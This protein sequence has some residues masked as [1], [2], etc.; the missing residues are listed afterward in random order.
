MIAAALLFGL[1]ASVVKALQVLF[2]PEA[3]AGRVDDGVEELAV[4]KGE[5]S[6]ADVL[7][8]SH[9]GPPGERVLRG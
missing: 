3:M 4:E 1:A 6:A 2:G 5:E 8:V 9:A 7:I